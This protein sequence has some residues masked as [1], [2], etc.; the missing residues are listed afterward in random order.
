ML[1]KAK[2]FHRSR[3]SLCHSTASKNCARSSESNTTKT[4]RNLK[5]SIPVR[6]TQNLNEA[7]LIARVASPS[8]SSCRG[9]ATWNRLSSPKSRDASGISPCDGWF[10]CEASR[11]RGDAAS[12]KSDAGN[13]CRCGRAVRWTSASQFWRHWE[14]RDRNVEQTIWVQCGWLRPKWSRN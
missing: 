14:H 13:W 1:R 11:L 7:C 4:L 8:M 12:R 9:L 6:G 3:S 2:S 10:L 5:F